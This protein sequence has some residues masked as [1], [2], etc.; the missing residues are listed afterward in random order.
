MWA[1]WAKKSA[2]FGL[3][4]KGAIRHCYSKVVCRKRV[5]ISFPTS[6]HL[7]N[8]T[9]ANKTAQ[10]C[11]QN[12]TH[13]PTEQYNNNICPTD[14][15]AA[16][17]K[18]LAKRSASLPAEPSE[19]SEPAVRS[20]ERCCWQ[21]RVQR[22]PTRVPDPG[23]G[24]GH[25][26]RAWHF[27]QPHLLDVPTNHGCYPREHC[28]STNDNSVRRGWGR[29]GKRGSVLHVMSN[30]PPTRRRI[31]TGPPRALAFQYWT[32]GRKLATVNSIWE[33]DRSRCIGEVAATQ[34]PGTGIHPQ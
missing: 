28:T 32:I 29:C 17:A 26:T 6:R 9:A 18:H 16:V 33:P 14:R 3:P 34:R 1:T 5:H 30:G 27:H 23:H 20:C 21:T 31:S 15:F 7:H 11:P 8:R 13:V 19:P 4:A 22:Q 25:P 10:T 2:S 12:S 24:G